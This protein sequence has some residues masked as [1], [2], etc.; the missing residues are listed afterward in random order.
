LTSVGILQI[1]V[2][3]IRVNPLYNSKIKFK[4]KVL[5]NHIRLSE[6]M[7]TLITLLAANN[8]SYRDIAS[9]ND[10]IATTNYIDNDNFSIFSSTKILNS[11]SNRSNKHFD[12]AEKPINNSTVDRNTDVLFPE[13]TAA[14][15]GC[16]S[17]AADDSSTVSLP[18]GTAALTGNCDSSA[19]VACSIESSAGVSLLEETAALTGC[20]SF[21]ADDSSTVSFPEGRT[22]LTENCNSVASEDI[23]LDSGTDVSCPEETS[24]LSENNSDNSFD[25]FI[26]HS[27]FNEENNK[28]KGISKSTAS[29]IGLGFLNSEIESFKSVDLSKTKIVYVYVDAM[30]QG[31]QKEDEKLCIM[32]AVGIDDKGTKYVLDNYIAK[33]ESTEDWLNFFAVLSERGFQAPN[34][35]IADGAKGIGAAVKKAFPEASLCHCWVHKCRDI[36]RLLP[37]NHEIMQEVLGHLKLIYNATCIYKARVAYKNFVEL[38]ERRY[39]KVVNSLKGQIDGL[40]TFYNFDPNLQT[41]LKTSNIVESLFSIV[42]SRIDR[43][44]GACKK[45]LLLDMI[46]VTEIKA[47]INFRDYP[48]FSIT[49]PVAYIEYQDSNYNSDPYSPEPGCDLGSGDRPMSFELRPQINPVS[50]PCRFRV[51]ASA[52]LNSVSNKSTRC[53]AAADFECR[54]DQ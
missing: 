41:Y 1:N 28:A 13:E 33:S 45:E 30:Y 26:I 54:A 34:A 43:F 36:I 37:K 18:E 23:I 21:A 4:S 14:L 27:I 44:R 39:P 29:R 32:T 25:S 6:D 38:Y 5:Q 20:S 42:R 10:K 12:N 47:M 11:N 53:L 40:L 35:V 48:L 15:T 3:K 51:P 19:V 52:S 49:D 7:K 46:T 8:V 31:V 9:L 50:V 17:F 2:P 22:A 24:V 16:Y